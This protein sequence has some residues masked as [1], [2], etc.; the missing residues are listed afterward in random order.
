MLYSGAR[1]LPQVLQVLQGM[2]VLQVVQVARL[3]FSGVLSLPSMQHL[4]PRLQQRLQYLR[5]RWQQYCLPPLL[6]P[7]T[8]AG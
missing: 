6:R 4:H 8:A 1:S 5:Q 2:Q 7:S 3:F